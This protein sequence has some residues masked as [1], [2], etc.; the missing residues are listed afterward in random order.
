[1]ASR[2][3]PVAQNLETIAT[4][5]EPDYQSLVSGLSGSGFFESRRSVSQAVRDALPA[6]KQ[7]YVSEL[8]GMLMAFA[9]L[10]YEESEQESRK[11]IIELAQGPELDLS[12][13]QRKTLVSRVLAIVACENLVLAARTAYVERNHEKILSG[14]DVGTDIRPMTSAEGSLE[15]VVLWHSLTVQYL[16]RSSETEPTETFVVGHSDLI[17][18]KEQ[19]DDALKSRQA[20]QEKMALSGIPVWSPYSPD[21]AEGSDSDDR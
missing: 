14:S 13:E 8:A 21:A 20:L 6:D 15:S 16:S 7:Q 9:R 10:S 18:L 4:L 2:P 17:D 3:N 5:S 11:N 1:M 12:E 19:I